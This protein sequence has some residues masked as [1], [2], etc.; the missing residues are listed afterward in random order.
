VKFL[1]LVWLSLA[2]AAFAR[3]ED[4]DPER[5]RP[6]A[7]TVAEIQTTY[8]MLA[9]YHGRY[10][11]QRGVQ[12]PELY[13]AD[14]EFTQT[15]LALVYLAQGYPDTKTVSKSELTEFMRTFHPQVNDVQQARHLAAQQGWYILSGTRNDDRTLELPP[16]EYKLVSLEEAYP[17]FTDQRR[18]EP[19]GP[20]DWERIKASYGYRC[21]C[22]GS[23]EGEPHLRWPETVTRLQ[24]GHMDPARPLE[25][26]NIIPQ[27][28]SCNQTG[29][30]FWIYDD[31]GRVVALANPTVVDR[32]PEAVQRKIYERLYLKFDGKAPRDIPGAD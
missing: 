7:L 32:C 27:C 29:R 30:N 18:A 31:K 12:L 28:Q 10:L 4:L 13:R 15:A 6:A 24:K 19:V 5:A 23:K 22:C 2:A 21:A 11:A 8:A 14:G 20:L 16:G 25:P 3:G 26:G 17:G 9:E 1:L